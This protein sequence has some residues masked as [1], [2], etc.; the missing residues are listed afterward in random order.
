[1]FNHTTMQ[2]NR[3]AP[4]NEPFPFPPSPSATPHTRPSPASQSDPE[5]SGRP[6]RDAQ[7]SKQYIYMS[8]SGSVMMIVFSYRFNHFDLQQFCRFMGISVRLR[9]SKDSLGNT[10]CI[11]KPSSQSPLLLTS[12]NKKKIKHFQNCTL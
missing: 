11:S 10:R 4:Q 1:M 12:F 3:P 8:S 5:T 2:T 9:P 7:K 6:L